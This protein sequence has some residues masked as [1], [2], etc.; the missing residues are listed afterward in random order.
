MEFT[1]AVWFHEALV[2]YHISKTSDYVFVARLL[3]CI[4]SPVPQMPP[5]KLTL[6]KVG[7]QWVSDEENKNL[8]EDIQY[9]IEQNMWYS[10]PAFLNPQ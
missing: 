6:R 8:L 10:S 9:S 5:Q 7:R 3:G 2:H 4:H 1:C